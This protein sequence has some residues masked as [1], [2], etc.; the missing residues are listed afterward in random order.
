MFEIYSAIAEVLCIT[1]GYINICLCE[2]IYR[3]SK[4]RKKAGFESIIYDRRTL[5]IFWIQ[6]APTKLSVSMITL[7]NLTSWKERHRL[8]VERAGGE[9]AARAQAEEGRRGMMATLG[10]TAG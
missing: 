6:H 5:N 10:R 3:E 7:I 9:A 1:L 8:Y 2:Y 4:P